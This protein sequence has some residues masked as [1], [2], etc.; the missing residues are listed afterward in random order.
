MAKPSK[1]FVFTSHQKPRDLGV[2]SIVA[3]VMML[4]GYLIASYQKQ[5]L[6]LKLENESHTRTVLEQ[7]NQR[8]HTRLSELEV[9]EILATNKRE[10]TEAELRTLQGQVLK[11]EEQLSFYQRVMAPEKT[12]DG[13]FIDS[14]QIT[15]KASENAYRLQALLLQQYSQKVLLKGALKIVI[16]GSKGGKPYWLAPGETGFLPDGPIAWRFRYFQALDF[17]FT[18]P[19]DFIPEQVVFSSDVYKWKT[20]QGYYELTLSW[21]EVFNGTEDEVQ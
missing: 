5:A 1:F 19:V 3:V 9:S 2:F 14:V 17:S 8:L 12:Q 15:P 13:F 4:F 21:P 16:K 7:E 11:L 6:E 10:N 20:N 18:L